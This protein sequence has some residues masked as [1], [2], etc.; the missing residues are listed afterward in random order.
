MKKIFLLA[1][2]TLLF[3]CSDNE[4]K[5]SLTHDMQIMLDA[6][7]G[8]SKDSVIYLA[9]SVKFVD[10]LN[11]SADFGEKDHPKL[12]YSANTAKAMSSAI[13]IRLEVYPNFHGGSIFIQ[14]HPH[15]NKMIEFDEPVFPAKKQG[16]TLQFKDSLKIADSTYYDILE[17]KTPVD[18]V[19]ACNI[20]AFYYGIHD[21]IVKVISKNG[22]Q[23]NRVPAK[24]YEDAENRRA[25]ERA[26]IDSIAQAVADS[27][28]KANTPAA[29]DT[30]KKDSTDITDEINKK[31][32]EILDLADSIK[33]C[34]KNAYSSGSLSAIKDCKI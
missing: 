10:K 34:I 20:S 11:Q 24:V 4:E 16:Y 8:F 25:K 12:V 33:N 21:G 2:G 19:N 23:L 18:S 22:V 17:F 14:C 7:K 6:E 1:L 13:D 31:T 27:I 26:Q 15:Q 28:I 29:I 9:D 32:Q 3:A 5:I 30:S